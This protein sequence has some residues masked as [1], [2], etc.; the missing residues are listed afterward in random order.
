MQRFDLCRCH[1]PSRWR[2]DASD[3]SRVQGMRDDDL[4]NR[5]TSLRQ[6][7]QTLGQYSV[8]F[9]RNDYWQ[10]GRQPH[11]PQKFMPLRAYWACANI[12]SLHMIC[13][14]CPNRERQ[15]QQWLVGG[16]T[17]ILGRPVA[18]ERDVAERQGF[19]SWRRFPAY[20]LSK[21][22]LLPRTKQM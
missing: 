8:A 21:R 1:A 15:W 13:P 5:T 2:N 22:A 18:H 12:D 17:H 11:W 7:L 3:A 4:G 10:F 9:Q 20:T 19:D 6:Q 14:R 16:E